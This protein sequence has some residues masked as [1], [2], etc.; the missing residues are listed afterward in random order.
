MHRFQSF[1]VSSFVVILICGSFANA[2]SGDQSAKNYLCRD[3]G[4]LDCTK[5]LP[6][7]EGVHL[8]NEAL[9]SYSSG[10]YGELKEKCCSMDGGEYL[11]FDGFFSSSNSDNEAITM[12]ISQSF[13]LNQLEERLT[14]FDED[15]GTEYV[16]RLLNA[17]P[18]DSIHQAVFWLI[19]DDTYDIYPDSPQLL[20]RYAIAAVYFSLGGSL[21][22]KTCWSGK[23]YDK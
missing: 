8:Y 15:H 3:Q 19:Y 22:W 20:Q 6:I 1:F 10:L 14:A 11:F 18:G 23:R 7:V 12:S 13:K 2:D 4:G 5:S 9:D 17:T 21:R 16:S